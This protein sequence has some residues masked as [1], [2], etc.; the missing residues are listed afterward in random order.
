MNPLDQFTKLFKNLT[1]SKDKSILGIDVGTSAI[2]V[3]QMRESGGR[4]V[5]E[6]YGSLALGPYEE[7][8]G[9]VGSVASLPADVLTTALQ[10]LLAEANV[11]TK[12]IAVSIPSASTLVFTMS[13]PASIKEGELKSVVP[14]E[15]R[16]YIPV[17]ISEVSL[18][19]WVLPK[20]SFITP[21]NPGA[22][23]PAKETTVLVVAVRKDTVADF[24]TVVKNAKLSQDFFEVEAF[25]SVRAS[26]E[27]DLSSILVM[28]MGASR[29]KL[30]FLDGGVVRDVHVINRGS[31]D[32]TQGLVASFGMMFKEAEDMKK[33]SGLNITDEAKRK[34]M[35]QS[36]DF[37]ISEMKN[38]VYQYEQKHGTSIDHMVVSGG[39]VKLKGFL[40]YI[41]EELSFDVEFADPFS[42][43][44]APEF[45]RGSLREA[46]P[47]FAVAVGLCLRGLRNG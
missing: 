30:V 47:E 29:T 43:T 45:L 32:I 21:D 10:N 31:E 44:E 6:T 22:K 39:G 16:R 23:S 25:S 33:E 35:E 1:T 2:K 15:A 27:H 9:A 17:D 46:G 26:V 19:W 38:A 7:E 20:Q 36:L 11:T 14:L 13:F 18:D 4:A 34:N 42:Q 3:V 8:K 24:Q 12:R 40:P 41:N 5:L 28:D 37:I